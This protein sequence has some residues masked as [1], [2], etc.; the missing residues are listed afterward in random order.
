M[1][2]TPEF[3]VLFLLFV[4]GTLSGMMVIS[5]ASPIAQE[6]LGITPAAAG[7][8][9]SLIAVGMVVGKVAWG[10]VSDRVGR[11]PVF[12]ALFLIAAAALMVLASATSHAAV[13]ACMAAVASCY[14]GF[15]ALMGPVTADDFGTTYLGV[16][17]GIMFFTVA[18]SSFVGP[19]IAGSVAEASG[20][21]FSERSSS[22]PPSACSASGWSPSTRCCGAAAGARRRRRPARP[23]RPAA[24]A[25]KSSRQVRA[26]RCAITSSPVVT[27]PMTGM[28]PSMSASCS[29]RLPSV[30]Q[31]DGT[32][33]LKPRSAAW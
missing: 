9:V 18:V 33:R 1:M 5:H 27:R 28:T 23:G 11:S 15:L 12:V 17:F 21:S 7:A 31:S 26:Q 6:V 30:T 22:P 25:A 14:G 8:I 13:A 29:R 4:A 20:G 2:R 10:A 24:R 19:R 3:L 16:N 32:M